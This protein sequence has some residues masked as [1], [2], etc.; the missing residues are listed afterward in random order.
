MKAI[1]LS[2]CIFAAGVGVLGSGMA[3]LTTA[4]RA[5]S[6]PTTEG[7]LLSSKCVKYHVMSEGSSFF[8]HVNY[9]YTIAGKSYPGDRLA[10][11]Y[12]GSGWRRPNQ[13][14]ADRLS[15][16]R[17]V[18][19]RYDPDKPSTAVLSYGLN[20]STATRMLAGIWIMLVSAALALHALRPRPGTRTL[21]LS[22]GRNRLALALQGVGGIVLLVVVGLILVWLGG[23]LSDYGILDTLVTT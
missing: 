21:S 2:L 10:F 4:R 18:L 13:K 8:T 5:R 23:L 6:W 19:V 16:A 22:W 9:R 1:L 14:I 7:T 11:G 12:T 17:Q 20:G 3:N 15:S